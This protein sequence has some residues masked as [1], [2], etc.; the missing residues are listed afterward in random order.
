MSETAKATPWRLEIG[1]PKAVAFVDVG[2]HVVE[3]RLGGADGE[4]A[5]GDP[6]AVDALDVVL[7]PALAEQGAGGQAD[8]LEQQAAGRGG[9]QAHR[10]LRPRPRGPWRPTRSTKSAGPMPSASAAT[11]KSSQSAARATSDL[12]PSRTQSSPS[13]R[14]LRLE[15][16]RVEERPRLEDRQRRGGHVLAGEGG[17]VGRLLVGAAPVADRGRDGAGR[18]RRVGDPEVAVG[19]RLADQDAG[20][21]GLLVHDAAELLG[22]AEHV[23]AELRRSGRA[24]PSGSRRSASASSAAGRIF[25][26]A[27]ERPASWNIC[28][29]SSGVT[30]KRPARL[31]RRLAGR[32]AQLLGRLEGA[33]GGGRGAE[34]ALGR[35]EERSSRPACGSGSG[36]A[37]PTRRG[38]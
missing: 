7:A 1:S 9:A 26:S 11:T 25:S 37:G 31:A 24:A 5:P 22:D 15:L 13:L 34:A 4:A 28:C 38:G 30:S 21:R 35:L 17:Q 16:Q 14:A 19:E 12:A 2:D 33:A 32:F 29:S 20:H 10:R 3:H 8:A 36:R 18:E 23:D 27:K 6:R